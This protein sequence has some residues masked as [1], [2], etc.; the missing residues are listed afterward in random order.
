LSVLRGSVTSK[1]GTT[2]AALDSFESQGFDAMVAAAV[3][4]AVRRGRELSANADKR[5]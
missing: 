1:G 3:S 4:A 5:D 2:E